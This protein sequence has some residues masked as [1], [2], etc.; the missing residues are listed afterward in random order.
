[1]KIQHRRV[2]GFATLMVSAQRRDYS[3]SV[4]GCGVSIQLTVKFSL[5]NG[6]LIDEFLGQGGEDC[7]YQVVVAFTW[8]R[9]GL[10]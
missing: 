2:V 4:R 5:S 1:M 8:K 10:D 3:S 6:R 7:Q 9:L